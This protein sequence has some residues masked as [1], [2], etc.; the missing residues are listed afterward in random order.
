MEKIILE[1]AG[2]ISAITVI[3][4]AINKIFDKKLKPI[5]KSI[6]K[7]DETQC[8]NFLVTFLKGIEKGEIMDEVEIKRA[9]EIYDHYKDDLHKNSYIH[10][11]WEKL[12]K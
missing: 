7:L 6:D 1:I 2:L 8:K 12:M 5:C 4:T 3:L 9:Y 10:D 11:K